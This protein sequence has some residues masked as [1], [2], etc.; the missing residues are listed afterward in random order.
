MEKSTLLI[1]SIFYVIF[2]KKFALHHYYALGVVHRHNSSISN[3]N[4]LVGLIARK[5]TPAQ[6]HLII[7]LS[8]EFMEACF[9]R[10]KYFDSSRYIN[11]LYGLKRKRNDPRY[12]LSPLAHSKSLCSFRRDSRSDFHFSLFLVLIDKVLGSGC[13]EIIIPCP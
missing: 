1:Y 10:S 7:Q 6:R 12:S 3:R 11:R 9:L 4:S 8:L 13:A 2:S 5:S